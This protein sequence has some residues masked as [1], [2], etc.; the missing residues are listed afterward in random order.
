MAD[1]DSDSNLMAAQGKNISELRVIDLKNEL[2][3]RNEDIKGVKA[4]LV[5]RLKAVSV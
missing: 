4:E 1:Q 2:Q 3:K 5:T